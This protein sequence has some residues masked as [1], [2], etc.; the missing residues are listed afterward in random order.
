M[1][2]KDLNILNHLSK[3]LFILGNTKQAKAKGD[4]TTSRMITAWRTVKITK[5]EKRARSATPKAKKIPKDIAITPR[6][7]TAAALPESIRAIFSTKPPLVDL[8]KSLL[9]LVK[10]LKIPLPNILEISTPITATYQDRFIRIAI[11]NI[12]GSIFLMP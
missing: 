8:I 5:K 7:I 3:Y 9:A 6:P 4:T 1:K 12:L 2:S 10:R 11:T